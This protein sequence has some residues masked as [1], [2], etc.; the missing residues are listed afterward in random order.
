MIA[1][2]CRK[3]CNECMNGVEDKEAKM[4]LIQNWSNK[5]VCVLEIPW[6]SF[7]SIFVSE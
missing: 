6:K 5:C 4:E 3:T 2:S 1:M 7:L